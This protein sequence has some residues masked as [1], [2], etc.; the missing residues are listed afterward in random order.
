[1]IPQERHPS[2]RSE[3]RTGFLHDNENKFDQQEVTF[4]DDQIWQEFLTGSR[5]LAPADRGLFKAGR[6]KIL[7]CLLDSKLNW[8]QH[9]QVARDNWA[10]QAHPTWPPEQFAL[11]RW[12]CPSGTT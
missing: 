12:L 3:H 5:L 8:L 6:K 1:M 2:L 4:A 10:S 11:A 7:A 9:V